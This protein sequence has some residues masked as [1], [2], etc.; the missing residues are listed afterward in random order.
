M[1]R[2]LHPILPNIRWSSRLSLANIHIMSKYINLYLHHNRILMFKLL[3]NL[4]LEY[5]V[6]VI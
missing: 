4:F 1:G 5:H 6:I 3:F 2:C